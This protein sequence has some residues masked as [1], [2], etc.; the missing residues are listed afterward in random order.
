MNNLS[1][2]REHIIN[3]AHRLSEKLIII[4]KLGLSHISPPLF[5]SLSPSRSLSSFPPRHKTLTTWALRSKRFL[6]ADARAKRADATTR[7]S[8]VTAHMWRAVLCCRI[9][10]SCRE[11]KIFFMHEKTINSLWKKFIIARDCSQMSVENLMQSY[12]IFF[13]EIN[14]MLDSSIVL[15][16]CWCDIKIRTFRNTVL[17]SVYISCLSDEKPHKYKNLIIPVCA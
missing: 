14:F 8:R 13:L 16:L 11:K 2:G 17:F 6:D 1:V 15:K 9:Y 3:A 7:V 4:W 10:I 12:A 5:L